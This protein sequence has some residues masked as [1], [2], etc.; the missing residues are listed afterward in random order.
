MKLFDYILSLRRSE[1]SKVA[2]ER[3]Q[4]ILQHERSLR[5][6]GS[7]I[8]IKK[9][10]QDILEVIKKYFP[11]DHQDVRVNVER[12]GNYEILELNITLPEQENA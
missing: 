12:D 8:C 6:R 7:S 3:L 10:Q 4:L 9:M 11:I 1:S 2:K 5:N